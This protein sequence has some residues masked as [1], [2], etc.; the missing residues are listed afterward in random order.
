MEQ[1][2]NFPC[3]DPRS[4]KANLAA[5]APPQ[6]SLICSDGASSDSG[7]SQS[8]S[9][10]D[11][12]GSSMRQLREQNQQQPRPASPIFGS[13]AGRRR[14]SSQ[15]QTNGLADLSSLEAS[16]Q[17]DGS[18]NAPAKDLADVSHR[19][20]KL[21]RAV[22]AHLLAG[23]RGLSSGGASILASASGAQQQSLTGADAAA[24]FGSPL[25]APSIA[26]G[27]GPAAAAAAG[28][29]LSER[30]QLR[31][32]LSGIKTDIADL[33]VRQVEAQMLQQR[34]LQ[35]EAAIAGMGGLGA[36][37]GVAGPAGMGLASGLSSFAGSA[38]GGGSVLGGAAGARPEPAPRLTR[39][40]SGELLKCLLHTAV[41]CACTCPCAHMAVG[42]ACYGLLL[43][44]AFVLQALC[45]GGS[46]CSLALSF[47][48][49]Q[50]DRLACIRSSAPAAN[51]DVSVLADRL[52]HMEGLMRELAQAQ[53]ANTAV[54][55]QI[56]GRLPSPVPP[57][58]GSHIS[59]SHAVPAGAFGEFAAAGDYRGSPG[60]PSSPNQS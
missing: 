59:S 31:E 37:T 25:F 36:L 39:T 58:P 32:T 54:L 43:P 4:L 30:V 53:V 38:V 13:T 11:S 1:E 41:S 46:C 2:D 45:C 10:T 33:A 26:D 9:G 42:A 15:Q 22:K 29:R 8:S 17:A 40:P 20:K 35:L 18:A 51:A 3:A 52:H 23:Q 34:V 7:T 49:A 47:T 48:G 57:S 6:P 16:L 12:D 27:T 19:L 60:V 24:S 14:P 56:G 21:E 50:S 28:P 5:Q 44:A 55:Q